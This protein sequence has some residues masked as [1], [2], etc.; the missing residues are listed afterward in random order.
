MDF[1]NIELEINQHV[2]NIW[3]N[4]PSKKNA[5]N[6][7]TIDELYWAVNQLCKDE[8]VRVI[9]IGGRGDTFCAG[10]DL[11]HLQKISEYNILENTD[12]SKAL[13]NALYA[14][15]AAPK[16]IIARVHGAALAGG[17]GLATVC[18]IVV[19]T[20]NSKFGF[21]EV[22]IGFIPAIVSVFALRKTLQIQTRELL[23]TG[24]IISADE[25]YKRGLVTTVVGDVQELD[26]TI[27]ILTN[28]I[29]LASPTAISLTKEML[30][31]LDN[32]PLEPSLTYAASMNAIARNT[33]D[34]KNGIRKFLEKKK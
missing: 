32:M 10:A 1:Q 27:N 9:V 14:I 2:G 30:I 26:N 20:Q 31:T 28:E 6:R 23:L 13:A 8:S 18:D 5:L 12:D 4:V 33:D 29:N 17:C 21:T 19:A 11:A 22:K 34:C 16:P 24:K 15:Y 3:L 7:Q 25:A